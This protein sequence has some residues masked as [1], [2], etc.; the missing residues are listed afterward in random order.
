MKG[1]LLKKNGLSIDRLRA[2]AEVAD[3]GSL[4]AAA[5]QDPVRQSQYSRQIRDLESFFECPLTC[6]QSGRLKM[7]P[8][9]EELARMSRGFLQGLEHFAQIRQGEITEFRLGLT[10]ASSAVACPD[11]QFIEWAAS[12]K[13]RL[14]IQIREPSDLLADV[15]AFRL[16]GAVVRNAG[17]LPSELTASRFGVHP[18][19]LVKR[20]GIRA[21]TSSKIPEQ[22]LI[23]VQDGFDQWPELPFASQV[24][25]E[26]GCLVTTRMAIESGVGGVVI[27]QSTGSWLTRSG[28]SNVFPLSL[29]SDRFDLVWSPRAVEMRP[30]LEPILKNFL[31]AA[32]LNPEGAKK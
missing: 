24:V 16:D 28:G 18:L 29:G 21:K 17:T 2:L 14:A 20:P 25:M 23:A 4:A 12:Q 26:C 32:R 27:D 22:R 5:D 8:A 1:N 15:A 7:N 30:R 6:R 3:Y 10:S 11:T 19:V 9:G 31:K 13:V